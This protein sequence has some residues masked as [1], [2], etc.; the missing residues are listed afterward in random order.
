MVDVYDGGGGKE[1]VYQM[2]TG[3]VT[4]PERLV[5][6]TVESAEDCPGECIMLE[7]VEE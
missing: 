6:S 5:E 3:M 2:A 1:P 4:V 7:L